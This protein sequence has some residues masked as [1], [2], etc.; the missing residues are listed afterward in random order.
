MIREFV[1]RKPTDVTVCD[2]RY[3]CTGIGELFDVAE[4]LPN[5]TCESFSY[6]TAPLAIPRSRIA[7]LT[8]RALAES[9]RFQR[10]NTS[11]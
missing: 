10:D 6:L 5:S 7:Q 3:E 8:T 1:D 11:L 9:D 2:T 4:R